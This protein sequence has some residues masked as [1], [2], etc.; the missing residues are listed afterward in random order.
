MVVRGLRRRKGAAEG[1]SRWERSL[2]KK[3]KSSRYRRRI[4]LRESDSRRVGD[5]EIGVFF[6]EPEPPVLLVFVS[7]VHSAFYNI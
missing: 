4:A 2:V 3:R 1:S 5:L 6:C 7:T